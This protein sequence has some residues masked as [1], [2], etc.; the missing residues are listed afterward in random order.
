MT[1]LK[2]LLDEAAGPEPLVSDADVSADLG[3]ARQAARRR[4][5]TGAGLTAVAATVTLAA[6]ATPLLLSP[7]SGQEAATPP[8]Q[9]SV[10]APGA[11]EP[12]R[13]LTAGQVLLVAAAAAERAEPTSGQ[14]FRVR[15]A[16]T[17]DLAVNQGKD[18]YKIRE[19]MVTE[20]WTGRAGG[21]AYRGTRSLGAKPA[22][23]A[24]KAAWRRHGSPTSWN[25]GKTDTVVPKD[26]I[27][28]STPTRGEL[29]ELPEEADRYHALGAAGVPLSEV[30][31]LPTTPEALRARLLKDK[32]ARAAAA[33]NTSYLASMA[34]GLLQ[35]TPA[36]PKVRAAALRLLAGLPG[37][38]VE[39]NVTDALGRKGTA[40]QFSFPSAWLTIRL[41]IDPVSGKFL[42]SEHGGGKSRET[43]GLES[44]WTN[45]KPTPPP[46]ALR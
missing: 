6:L 37:A 36:P 35:E 11:S 31:A 26:Q 1:D 29:L 34:A 39:Q 8:G 17:R 24:D 44:G 16:W 14:Y 12:V 40:V 42:S 23:A 22:T 38:K 41:I 7:N 25:L 27:I 18:P 32:A 9:P 3:R 19:T 5:F 21:T 33:D 20:T 2:N 28:R 45:N 15:V 46:T 10:S 4:R 43:V 30:L 13:A